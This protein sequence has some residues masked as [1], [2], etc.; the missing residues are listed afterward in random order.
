M[1][2]VAYYFARIFRNQNYD[3]TMELFER[4][5][6]DKR[7]Q[8][9]DH[10]AFQNA[11]RAAG[12]SRPWETVLSL[13]DSASSL[14]GTSRTRENLEILQEGGVSDGVVAA[15]GS[16]DA[17]KEEQP[18]ILVVVHSALTN[19]KFMKEL[20]GREAMRVGCVTS[21]DMTLLNIIGSR[22]LNCKLSHSFHTGVLF[23]LAAV[24]L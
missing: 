1:L 16:Q 18:A 8:R 19:L 2:R 7:I 13:L 17:T 4:I 12:H 21:Y 14:F 15:I 3:E 11:I 10:V 22:H 24:L 6:N 23:L 9:L 20:D 5:I